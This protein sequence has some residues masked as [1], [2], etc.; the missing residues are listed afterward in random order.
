[1]QA[2]LSVFNSWDSARAKVYREHMQIAD[3]W[4]TAVIIQ[5][6]IFG[7]LHKESGSGVLFTHDTQDNIP[8]IN[9]TGDFSFLSQGEDIVAGLINTLPISENQRKDTIIIVQYL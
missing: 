4:G 6:M 3:E 1:M 5:Q 2:V 9:L 7:N 8:G